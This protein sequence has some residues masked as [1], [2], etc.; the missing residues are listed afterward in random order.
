[1]ELQHVE[2]LHAT[3][4]QAA[5]VIY[6]DYPRQSTKPEVKKLSGKLR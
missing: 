6:S 5:L 4:P 2:T 3:S 1:M